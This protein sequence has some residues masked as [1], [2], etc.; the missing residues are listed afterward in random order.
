MTTFKQGLARS[1]FIIFVSAIIV[2]YIALQIVAGL[3]QET[4]IGKKVVIL[5][6]TLDIV[7]YDTRMETVVLEDGRVISIH[8]IKESIIE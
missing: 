2:A 5:G 7:D 1:I 4:I 3:N 8:F 6:D